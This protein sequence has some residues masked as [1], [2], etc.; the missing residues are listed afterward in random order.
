MR[1][2]KRLLPF[3]SGSV[4]DM[5]VNYTSISGLTGASPSA[6]DGK[7]FRRS[8]IQKYFSGA[9]SS[10]VLSS[11]FPGTDHRRR[12]Y[13][14]FSKSFKGAIASCSALKD[15]RGYVLTGFVGS[16]LLRESFTRPVE[17]NFHIGDGSF[18]KVIG[19]HLMSS[20]N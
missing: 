8:S 19:N 14:G 9:K 2:A 13:R 5:A 10:G 16:Q 4:V 15:A 11:D 3:P 7:A 1:L 20:G 18:V 6:F 12:Y 17:G